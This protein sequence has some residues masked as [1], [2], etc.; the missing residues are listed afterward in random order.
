MS[1]PKRCLAELFGTFWLV[2]L[3][4]GSAV[5]TASFPNTGIGILGVALAFGMAVMS[6]GYMIGPISGAHLNPAVSIAT[7]AARQFQLVEFLAY[8]LSQVVGACL[9]AGA[10]L[11]I[12]S[13]RAGFTLASGFATNGFGEFSPGGYKL[14]AALI[15]EILLTFGFVCVVLRSAEQ[16]SQLSPII[17]GISYTLIHLVGIPISNGSFNPARSTAPALFVGGIAT[18]QLWVFWAAPLLG[19]LLAGLA[20]RYILAQSIPHQADP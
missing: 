16:S 20:Y 3:G 7:W 14:L 11:V 6:M 2:L 8:T 12:A 17:N 19:G 4:C 15:V 13:R 1:L 5:I 9:G 18:R 10:L